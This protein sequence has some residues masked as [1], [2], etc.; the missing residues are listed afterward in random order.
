MACSQ[1]LAC[2]ADGLNLIDCGLVTVVTVVVDGECP[3]L[4][5][6]SEQASEVDK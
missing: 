4:D 1:S 5:E 3:G 6:Q 2:D